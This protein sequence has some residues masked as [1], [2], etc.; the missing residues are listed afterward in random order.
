MK[1]ALF[2]F[3]VVSLSMTACRSLTSVTSIKANES[4]VLGNNPHGSYTIQLRNTAKQPLTITQTQLD[5]TVKSTTIAKY[6]E[7]LTLQVDKNTAVQ[8][9]NKSEKTAEVE[10][11]IV[12]DTHLSMGYK[13]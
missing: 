9:G 12:G 10:L 11:K 8:I 6:K 7:W 4:F 3:L 13:N 1:N 5:G 2:I